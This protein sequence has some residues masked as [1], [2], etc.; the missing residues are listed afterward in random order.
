MSV[1]NDIINQTV[2]KTYLDPRFVASEEESSVVLPRELYRYICSFLP[3]EDFINKMA[4]VTKGAV[5]NEDR[6]HRL[7]SLGFANQKEL[8]YVIK[9]NE[10]FTLQSEIRLDFS[11]EYLNAEKLLNYLCIK[12]DD[13]NFELRFPQLIGLKLQCMPIGNLPKPFITYLSNLQELDLSRC[14]DITNRHLENIIKCCPNL[15]KLTLSYSDKLSGEVSLKGLE[16]LEI[17]SMD[18]NNKITGLKLDPKAK[19][20]KIA[21]D[22][23]KGKFDFLENAHDLQE[24]KLSRINLINKNLEEIIHYC[25]GLTSLTLDSWHGLSGE[26]SLE[27]LEKLEVLY[28]PAGTEITGLKLDP[29]AKIKK[30]AIDG[31][32]GL[33]DFLKD[34]SELQELE[35]SETSLTYDELKKIIQYCPN[36]KKL[37]LNDQPNFSGEVSLEGLAKLEVLSIRSE[38]ITSLK[39]D[40][41]AKIEKINIDCDTLQFDC[42]KNASELRELELSRIN[43]A[44]LTKSDIEK[45]VNYFPNLTNLSLSN[46]KLPGELPLIGLQKLEALSIIN[47]MNLTRL[48]LDQKATKL[49][50]IYLQHSGFDNF[51]FLKNAFGLQKLDLYGIYGLK[52]NALEKIIE[53]CPN[54]QELCLVVCES[55]S[56]E[57]SLKGLEKLKTLI[58]HHCEA[59][60]DLKLDPSINVKAL[61]DRSKLDVAI[62]NKLKEK[63]GTAS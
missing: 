58:M 11:S 29:K 47:C 10:N 61:I 7:Q 9:H 60:T 45:V 13:G 21:I 63:I 36:L 12:K 5:V 16:K 15:K 44:N 57:V 26:V 35:L 24:I 18:C 14:D 54:L 52:N 3:I 50:E 2:Q 62:I 39:L 23:Y 42:L 59:V 19:I 6:L 49:K 55:L 30:I 17:L 38:K 51:D 34:A 33:F 56:G 28:V 27:G 53:W 31:Y 20:K 8:D 22:G 46:C 1:N 41:K 25:P 32:E 40:P 48:E 43:L 4:R 37:M